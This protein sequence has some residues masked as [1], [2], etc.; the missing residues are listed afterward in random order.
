M[1]L[2][3]FTHLLNRTVFENKYSKCIFAISSVIY[4]TY[5]PGGA[6]VLKEWSQNCAI[7]DVKFQFWLINQ[8]Q[9]SLK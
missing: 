4:R 9:C 2:E 6:I 1:I 5:I 8:L 7:P 3:I